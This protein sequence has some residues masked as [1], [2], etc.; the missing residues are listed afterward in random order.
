LAPWAD[1]LYACDAEWWNVYFDQVKDMGPELWTQDV[2]AHQRYGVNWAPA[3]RGDGLGREFI[4]WGANSG[5]QAINLA[6]L[7]GARR[8]ILLGYDCK[9]IEGKS[10]WFGEHQNGLSRNHPLDTW[11]R[12]FPQLAADLKAEGVEVLNCSPDSALDC[13]EKVELATALR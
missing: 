7:W 4:H 13:F 9:R 5:Y 10:H 12:N 1:V 3:N 8:I 6:Y 2:K 11:R